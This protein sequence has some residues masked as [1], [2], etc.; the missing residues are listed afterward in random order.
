MAIKRRKAW[1]VARDGERRLF[2]N[3][4]MLLVVVLALASGGCAGRSGTA[5]AGSGS[6]GGSGGVGGT[7]PAGAG[8]RGGAGGAG[9]SGTAGTGAPGGATGDGS[10]GA[11]AS[12]LA[13]PP[14]PCA[15]QYF[16]KGC[17]N[18]VASTTC[19]GQCTVANACSP[20]EDPGKS[21]LPKTFVC[22]RFMLFSDEMAQA[23]AD[24]TRANGW[25][26]PA[27]PPFNYAVAGHDPD[28]GGLDPGVTS[29]CCQCYQLL[30]DKPEGSVQGL[31]APPPL[32]VQSFNTAA[33]GANNF[34]VFM[35]AGGYGAFNACVADSSFG[36]TTKFASFIYDAFPTVNPNNGGV[37]FLTFPECQA[38]G[39]VTAAS[40]ASAACQA[41]I[42]QLCNQVTSAANPAVAAE[43]RASCL[44]S[45]QVASLY[46][47]N[48]Q[49][50][51]RK[52]E[53]PEALTRVTGCRLAASSLPKPAPQVRT[54]ADAAGDSSWRS[55]YTT[56]T[57]QDCCKPTCAWQD[58]VGGQGLVPSGPWQSFYSCDKNGQPLTTAAPAN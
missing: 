29:T 32:I 36:G 44:E 7:T 25:G 11:P 55:G 4:G 15:N 18:G 47:Q 52:V 14:D 57:M 58:S 34:D 2:E 16:V 24:D 3:A 48:W 54:P 56:T 1:L 19:G 41:R 51:A 49:V 10:A 39:M 28:T 23:A 21:A 42:T 43:T 38:N 9:A 45:N 46:H 12:Y 5:G 22:P 35:G 8:G 50:R 33:G 40:L 27:S 20:P 17:Q 13:N 6:A 30:F 31:P 26:D 53:C 37:K